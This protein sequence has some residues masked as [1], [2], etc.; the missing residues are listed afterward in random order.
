MGPTKLSPEDFLVYIGHLLQLNERKPQR[1]TI[2]ACPFCGAQ[3]WS[4]QGITYPL[5]AD[6][7]G[8]VGAPVV[9]QLTIICL[10][11]FFV[12][13][14][15]WQ[16]ISAKRADPEFKKYMDAAAKLINAEAKRRKSRG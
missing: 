8:Y 7:N 14:F 1:P 10:E 4:V 3:R 6:V 15:A 16:P 9:P 5:G 13:N 2:N 12:R 11:C